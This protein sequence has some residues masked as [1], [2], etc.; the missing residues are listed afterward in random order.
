MLIA[1]VIARPDIVRDRIVAFRAAAGITALGALVYTYFLGRANPIN[2]IHISPPGV[3]LV[4]VWLGIAVE[5]HG[6]RRATR[7]VAVACVAFLGALITVAQHGNIDLRF[8]QS[9]LGVLLEHTDRFAPD[10]RALVDNPPVEGGGVAVEALV[11]RLHLEHQPV[12]ILSIPAV[13]SEA[14]IRLGIA[15][16]AGT[17]QPCQEDL[18][19][20]APARALARARA[21]PVGS[22]LILGTG[23]LYSPLAPIDAYSLK[24]IQDRFVLRLIGGGGAG[25]A[26]YTLS[27]VR[28]TWH[29]GAA[30]PPPPFQPIGSP[31][32]G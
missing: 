28:P 26:A 12:T 14:L 19:R 13:E 6:G 8:G 25:L 11:R 4:F 22:A 16:A 29:G 3:A 1:I 10:V 5:A 30:V 21:L 24:L 18:S 9:A 7:F 32:C 2:L 17:T 20:T 31:G 27:S 23:P 15:N